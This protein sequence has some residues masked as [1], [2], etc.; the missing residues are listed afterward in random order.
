VGQGSAATLSQIEIMA[1]LTSL[2]DGQKTALVKKARLYA[3]ATAYSYEDLIQETYIRVLAG[4]RNWRRG[5][6]PVPFL[7]GVMRSVAWD[8]K[9]KDDP[10]SEDKEIGDEGA[11]ARGVMARLDIQ[12]VI[13]LF[14]DDPIAKRM[15]VEMMDGAKGEEL[16]VASGLNQTEYETKRK[17]I[18]RRLER[19]EGQ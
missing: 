4:D 14:D 9:R 12:A 19:W 3:R 2:T 18:R 11:E 17:K 13:S 10:L 1:E 16:Q 5:L 6:T 7:T 15:V 8:W